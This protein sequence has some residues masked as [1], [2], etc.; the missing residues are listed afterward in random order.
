METSSCSLATAPCFDRLVVSI[1]PWD[2]ADGR[3]TSERTRDKGT[4]TGYC[5][6]STDEVLLLQSHVFD[7][8]GHK[9]AHLPTYFKSHAHI[10]D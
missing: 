4:E 6:C 8:C 2:V 5:L 1:N 9:K 3:G 10:E 7:R